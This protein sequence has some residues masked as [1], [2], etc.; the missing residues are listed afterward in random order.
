MKLLL[1]MNLTPKLVSALKGRHI[2]T[3]HW[4][5]IGAPDAAD[6]EI[7]SY[8]SE[9][10]CVVVSHDLDFSTILSSTHGK[11]PSV[12]QLRTNYLDIEQIAE[13]IAATIDQFTNE[14]NEGAILSLDVNRS[15]LRML[16]L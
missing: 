4:Y 2:D 7:M 6:Y 9:N 16:P 10:D 13:L 3:I 11:K 12:I 15:R 8:A 5:T 14:I 1:D